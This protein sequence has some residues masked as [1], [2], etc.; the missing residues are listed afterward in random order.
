MARLN[1]AV[2]AVSSVSSARAVVRSARRSV[3]DG[4]RAGGGINRG[5]GID[6]G[7]ASD[8]LRRAPGDAAIVTCESASSVGWRSPVATRG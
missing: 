7:A 3:D 8:G 5:G 1:A 6:R 2:R 4:P